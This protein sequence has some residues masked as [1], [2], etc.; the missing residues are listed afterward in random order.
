MPSPVSIGIASAIAIVPWLALRMV[1]GKPDLPYPPGPKRLPVIG[2]ALDIDLKEPHV[3]YTTWGKT[4]GL[5][6]RLISC[7][8]LLITSLYAGDIVYSRTFGQDFVIVS[9]ERIAR[10]LADQRSATYSNRPHSPLYRM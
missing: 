6:F 1:W 8:V 9:S 5:Y 10:I 2:N 3:T 7:H 4:Y